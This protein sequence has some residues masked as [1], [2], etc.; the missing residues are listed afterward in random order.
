MFKSEI[1]DVE[2]MT[3]YPKIEKLGILGYNT[4]GLIRLSNGMVGSLHFS[5]SVAPS[6][7]ISRLEV[8]GDNTNV[9]HAIGTNKITLYGLDQTPQESDLE[10]KGARVWGHRQIDEHFIDCIIHHKQPQATVSDA[11]KAIEIAAKMT[12]S[13]KE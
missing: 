10:V 8:F 2:W 6:A 3:S 9:I 7:S 1:T 12:R 11:V 4:M 5:A 13:N